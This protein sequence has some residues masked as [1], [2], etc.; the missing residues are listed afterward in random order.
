MVL[1]PQRKWLLSV[2]CQTIKDL[3][4]AHSSPETHLYVNKSYWPSS[5]RDNNYSVSRTIQD[6]S[7]ANEAQHQCDSLQFL[8]M[9]IATWV[10]YTRTSVSNSVLTILMGRLIRYLAFQ[11]RTH[12]FVLPPLKQ[13]FHLLITNYRDCNR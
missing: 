4:K 5:E 13:E 8:C 2:V 3:F 9:Q 10:A 12:W 7:P 11:G 6:K 1:G